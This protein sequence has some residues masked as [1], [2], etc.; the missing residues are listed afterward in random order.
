MEKK[1]IL[2]TIQ[3]VLRKISKIDKKFE[4][5]LII[6]EMEKLLEKLKKINVRICTIIVYFISDVSIVSSMP[7]Q[8][9]ER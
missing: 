1:K 9:K 3:N 2:N 8:N 6:S 5:S 4:F 7:I